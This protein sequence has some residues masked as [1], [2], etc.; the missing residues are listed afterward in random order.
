[1]IYSV[2]G[3]NKH[4]EVIPLYFGTDGI[5]ALSQLAIHREKQAENELTNV[6]LLKQVS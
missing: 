6:F 1:M 5:T 3:I 2:I 4:G